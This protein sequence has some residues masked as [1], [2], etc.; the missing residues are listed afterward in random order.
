M[1]LRTQ[2]ETSIT[3]ERGL[4]WLQ[5][6]TFCRTSC[7]RARYCVHS[8]RRLAPLPA[9]YSRNSALGF[10]HP[11]EDRPLDA[12]LE[13]FLNQ[14]PPP[15]YVGFGSQ[16]FVH[17]ARLPDLA[18]RAG[19][20]LAGCRAIV[21]SG[22]GAATS[23]A[24][25]TMLVEYAPHRTLFRRVAAVVHHGGAG[26]FAAAVR[27][28]TPQ[29]IVPHYADQ[30]YW[31]Y[32]ASRLAIGPKPL[33]KLLVTAGRLARTIRSVLSSEYFRRNAKSLAAEIA[34]RDGLMHAAETI[35]S[36]AARSSCCRH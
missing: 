20:S 21:H 15:I 7:S 1:E 30:Y 12:R 19:S 24:S 26:T 11:P 25:N 3:K 22:D 32:R 9:E 29:I 33:M 6:A 8:T 13:E 16:K 14:G 36:Q 18:M 34:G 35:E 27:C 17:R 28:G 10:W 5:W 31:A 23:A 4:G 2:E